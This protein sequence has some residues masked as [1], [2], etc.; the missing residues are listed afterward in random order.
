MQHG[1]PFSLIAYRAGAARNGVFM[2]PHDTMLHGIAMPP[3]VLHAA[4]SFARIP[5]GSARDDL[6]GRPVVRACNT[7]DSMGDSLPL[8][9]TRAASSSL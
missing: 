1:I 3:Y 4:R 9:L 8:L 6:Q 5:Y 2:T 7:C